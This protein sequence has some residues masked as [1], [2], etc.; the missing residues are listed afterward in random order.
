[1]AEWLGCFCDYLISESL[2]NIILAFQPK[3]KHEMRI[4]EFLKKPILLMG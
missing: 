3:I 4:P 1:M 2:G